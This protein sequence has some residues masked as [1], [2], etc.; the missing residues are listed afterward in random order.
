[1]DIINK[2]TELFGPNI[3]HIYSN[4][5]VFTKT[6]MQYCYDVN[7]NK[8]V[9]LYNNVSHIGHSHPEI[10]KTMFEQYK[11]H[12]NNMRFL[13]KIPVEYAEELLNTL[14]EHKSLYKVYFTNSGSESNDLA[15][16]ISSLYLNSMNFVSLK[17][18]YH[19]TTYLCNL[20][21]SSSST[22]DFQNINNNNGCLFLDVNSNVSILP[23][24]PIL[25]HESIQGV[26]GNI[27][28]PSGYLKMLYENIKRNNGI[29]IADEVQT[30]FGRTG[31]TF[32]AFEF[33][34]IF[35]DIIT[36]GKSIGNGYPLGAILIRSEISNK[37]DE[38]YFNTYGGNSVAC[39]VGL[40]VLNNIK[41]NDLQYKSYE[42][43]EYVIY[44]LNH[45]K[46][47]YNKYI[48]NITGRGLF[49]G[50][51]FINQ[52]LA[53]YLF[54][55]LKTLYILVG[56]SKN[57]IRIK[58]PLSI[59]YSDLNYFL[60]S[61]VELLKLYNSSQTFQIPQTFNQLCN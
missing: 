8:Y 13:H 49:I 34:N 40:A 16:R 48:T 46:S 31:Y 58:P 53:L 14:G 11:T 56:I 51:H 25:I 32:W 23:D 7:N 27:T 21:S 54:E 5:P 22:G 20:V 61:L 17:D 60:D 24:K 38:P 18:G 35:P 15:L 6:Y 28:F 10:A 19:G 12:C 29:C 47:L 1:M 45:I 43:G 52:N 36:L 50:I 37:F 39:A 30:G 57:I 26:A 41:V 4:P 55:T 44:K 3:Y 9:D 59:T 2:R 42:Y 33:E